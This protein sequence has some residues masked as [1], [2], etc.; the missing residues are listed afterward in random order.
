MGVRCM[1]AL[2]VI[3]TL[4]GTGYCPCQGADDALTLFPVPDG[5]GAVVQNPADNKIGV[6][7]FGLSVSKDQIVLAF[8]KEPN[9]DN[10][11]HID[12]GQADLAGFGPGGYVAVEMQADNPVMMTG[13]VLADAHDFWSGQRTDLDAPCP[14]RKGDAEYRFYLE[15]I[16]GALANAKDCHLYLFLRD[17]GR[18]EPCAATATITR[19]SVHS[20]T[21]NWMAESDAWYE[22]QY[23]H[24]PMRDLSGIYRASYDNLVAWDAI[25][26]NPASRRLTL[27]GPWKKKYLGDLTWNYAAL[28]DKTWAAPDFDDSTWQQTQVPEAPVENQTGGHYIYRKKF[29]IARNA[30]ARTYLRLD[31]VSEYAEIYVNGRLVCCQTSATRTSAWVV[32]GGSIHKTTFGMGIKQVLAWQNF[33]RLGL[34]C[35]FDKS[36]I[37]DDERILLLPLYHGQDQWPL[38]MDIGSFLRDG[39]NTIA[40][41][42]YGCPIKGYWIFKNCPEDRCFRHVFGV[43]GDVW[44]L[45]N[46]SPL[47]ERLDSK[48]ASVGGDG[49]YRRDFQCR[50]DPAASKAV[51]SMQLSVDGAFPVR[52]DSGADGTWTAGIGLPADFQT[53][54][55]M[56]SAMDAEGRA[57]DTRSLS[58]IG[59]V[60]E[61]KDKQFFVNGDRFV[62]RGV[63]ASPGVEMDGSWKTTRKE[64]LRELR[65]FGGMGF[66]ALRTDSATQQNLD[67]ALAAG[68]M[69]M[70][71]CAPGSCDSILIAVGNLKAP[72]YQFSTDVHREMAIFLASA[73]NAFMWNIG[74]EFNHAPG[75]RDRPAVESFIAA[76]AAAVKAF[77]PAGRPAVY[78]NLDMRQWFFTGAQDIIGINI[79]TEPNRF[80]EDTQQFEKTVSPP[81]VITEWGLIGSEAPAT[82]DRNANIGKWEQRMAEKWELIKAATPCIG[83]FLYAHHGEFKDARGKAFIQGLMTPF[84]VKLVAKELTFTNRDVCPMRELDVALTT[85]MEVLYP[86][87]HVAELAPGATARITIP[88]GPAILAGLRFEISYETHRGLK[89]RFVRPAGTDTSVK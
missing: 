74:N 2:V 67:D 40:I 20:Q 43:L 4:L 72:D 12:L 13:M 19:V 57:L 27:N 47:I 11:I 45:V 5:H 14:V 53:H 46:P 56:V 3:A 81:Y 60:F 34:P 54:H 49:I 62:V 42:L 37:P 16:S 30:A 15:D 6:R 33:E 38:A 68:L 51:A 69:V 17:N 35:P 55:A 7:A 80:R 44:L 41:R 64:W 70:P 52:M 76:A 88:S 84:A 61:I 87:L 9:Q 1:F 21:P 58:Y 18:Q 78:S 10:Y 48:P 25:K 26:S 8:K 85:D 73:P 22:N 39:E 24:K 63:N 79:Y 50:L 28:Q 77:D 89:H 86:T 65:G 36:A 82:K 31:D 83:A 32:E 71:V 29:T 75:W 59:S 23:Q 66:N